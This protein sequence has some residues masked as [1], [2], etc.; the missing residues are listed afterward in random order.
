M[1]KL[2]STLVLL[3][4]FALTFDSCKKKTPLEFIIEGQVLDK[5]F[6]QAHEG[7]VVRLF[8]VPAATTQ[9]ILVEQQ[10]ITNGSYKF[11]FERDRSEKY[12]IRFSKDNYFDEAHTVFFSQLKVGE[13]YNLNFGVD[14]VAYMNWVFVDQPPVNANSSVTL[15]KLNGRSTGAGACPNQQYEYYGG[16]EP[17]TLRCAVGGNQ[18]IKF[19]I[20][21]L[22]NVTLDSV[23]CQAFEQSFYTVNF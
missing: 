3:V 13:V 6:N 19:Y 16:G 22:P 7:G 5:S 2:N 14:A 20:I 11:V 9:E 10:T 12:V 4:L 21:K 18:Y 23:F 1:K 17:D 15:Q 8:K